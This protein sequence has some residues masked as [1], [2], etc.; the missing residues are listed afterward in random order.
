MGS[1]PTADAL[2][3]RFDPEGADDGPPP[4]VAGVMSGTSDMSGVLSLGTHRFSNVLQRWVMEQ[5]A[6]SMHS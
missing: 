6:S 4:L 5:S 2:A 3:A 1:P